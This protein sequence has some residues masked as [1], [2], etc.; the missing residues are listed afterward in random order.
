MLDYLIDFVLIIKIVIA[1]RRRPPAGEDDA[2]LAGRCEEAE[3]AASVNSRRAAAA[4]AEVELLKTQLEAAEKQA[5]ELGWQ[6]QCLSIVL[7]PSF[8]EDGKFL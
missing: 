7:Q 4:E 3:L 2:A 6:V 8:S 5:N 1:Q